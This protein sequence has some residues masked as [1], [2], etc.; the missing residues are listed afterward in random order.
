MR[1][2]MV[3]IPITLSDHSLFVSSYDRWNYD[4]SGER[5]CRIVLFEV[6]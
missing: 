3:S 2:Q 4:S 5:R 6:I 1:V